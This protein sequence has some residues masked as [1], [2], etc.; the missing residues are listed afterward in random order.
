MKKIGIVIEVKDGVVKEA[1]YGM[2]TC[3]A[4]GKGEGDALMALMLEGDPGIDKERL[5]AHGISSILDLGGVGPWDPVCWSEAIM[6]TMNEYGITTLFG[7]TS[8]MGRELLPRIAAG[9]DAP[10]VMD[11][12]EVSC[13][14]GMARNYIYS[15]KVLATHQVEGEIQIYGVRPN[16]V[17]AKAVDSPVVADVLSV[18]CVGGLT[19]GEGS[20]DNDTALPAIRLMERRPGDVSAG[21][22]QEADVIVAGGRG[23]QNGEN[24]ALLKACANLMGG[25]VGA[26]RVAVD[27]GWVPYRMQVGQTGEKVSPRVYIAC[28]LSGSV[29]HF[30]GMKMSGMIIA[31]NTNPN[32]AIMANC[33]YFIEGDLFDVI[34]ALNEALKQIKGR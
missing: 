20:A 21:D 34:P 1:N 5:E 33:D 26:S 27:L 12:I 7:L 6:G 32:A 9:L 13:G 25:E 28:G 17:E 31:V 18:D 11:C 15:G 24:F 14:S 30:A 8:L 23:M 4:E 10:L 19:N 16:V 22:L 2:I 3:V 29:Q